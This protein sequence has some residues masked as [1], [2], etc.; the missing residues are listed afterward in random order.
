[1]CDWQVK[2]TYKNKLIV[3]IKPVA[4]FLKAMIKF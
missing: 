4:Q 1:M 2:T 3:L